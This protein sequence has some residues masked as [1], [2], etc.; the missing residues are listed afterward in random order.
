MAPPFENLSTA[1]Q[2]QNLRQRMARRLKQFLS[3]PDRFA[4]DQKIN[5]LLRDLVAAH[6]GLIAAFWPRD[7][8]PQ[9]QSVLQEVLAGGRPLAFPRVSGAEMRFVAIHDLNQ[10]QP[11]PF[12]LLQPTW[13]LPPAQ[14]S[15]IFVPLVAFDDHGHRLGRG[16]GYYDRALAAL[17]PPRPL[18]LGIAY[19]VQRTAQLPVAPHD[20]PLDA[21]L[22]EAGL[23]LPLD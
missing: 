23:H 15:L 8:E 9:I 18:T 4:A 1:E 7:D 3:G 22:S 16:K 20:V 2:K 19:G 13:D 5:M 10:L 21:V 14:P 11:G 17:G 6:K 12:N